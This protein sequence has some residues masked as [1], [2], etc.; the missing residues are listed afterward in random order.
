MSGGTATGG[1]EGGKTAGLRPKVV[2]LTAYDAESEGLDET[3][4]F[5]G[6]REFTAEVAVRG[7]SRPVVVDEAGEILLAVTGVGNV[8]AALTVDALVASPR[9]DCSE[10]YFLTVGSAG[11][12]PEVA[13][14]GSVVINDYILAWDQKHRYSPSDDREGDTWIETFSFKSDDEVCKTCD[15]VLVGAA[16]EIGTSVPLTDSESLWQCRRQYPFEAAQSEPSVSVGASVSGSEF[17]HGRACSAQARD[18][19][20]R[21]GVGRYYTTEME[22]FGTAIALH[23][24]GLLDRYLSVRGVSNFDRPHPGQPASESVTHDELAFDTCIENVS[25]VVSAIVSRILDNWT[26]W[27]DSVPPRFEATLS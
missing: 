16:R 21:Y 2:L 14:L 4:G 24:R 15:S 3:S 11:A 18:L 19:A 27:R 8:E 23:R 6:N 9:I 1:P 10:A 20:E 7:T 22:G 5:L 25:R 12:S 13:T 17:W 26:Q